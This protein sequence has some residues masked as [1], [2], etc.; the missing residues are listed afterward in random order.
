MITRTQLRGRLEEHFKTNNFLILSLNTIYKDTDYYEHITA[1][2]S[3]DCFM[4]NYDLII[5]GISKVKIEDKEIKLYYQKY[6]NKDIILETYKNILE[7]S[8]EK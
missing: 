2:M 3:S 1:T 4:D 6:I 7:Q 5:G 8:R